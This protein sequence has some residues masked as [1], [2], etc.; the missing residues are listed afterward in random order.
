MTAIPLV[1]LIGQSLG[2]FPRDKLGFGGR[3]P[4]NMI[5]DWT[6][7]A[8]TGHYRVVGD[9]TDYN[10]ALESL[11]LPVMLLSLSGDPL[12]PRP[13]AD[14]LARKLKKARVT[15]V[16]LQAGDYGM[17]AFSHFSW[18]KKPEPVLEQ[19]ESW[20]RVTASATS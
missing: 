18:V 12:I 10:A 7:E 14:F 9:N 15:Q 5:L 20:Q 13:C 17:K 8:L 1:R 11:E 6:H 4:L 2:F 19:V 16:E 3:Q